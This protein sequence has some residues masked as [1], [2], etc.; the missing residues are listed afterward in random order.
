[1][2]LEQDKLLKIL[3]SEIEYIENVNSLPIGVNE[4]KEE[5]I[6]KVDAKLPENGE[7]FITAIEKLTSGAKSGLI[8]NRNPRFFGYVLAGTTPTA[9][10]ADWLTTIWNQN[11]QV[12]NSSPAAS[13]FEEIVASWLLELLSLPNDSSMGFVTGGQMA[14]FTAINI[15]RNTVLEKSGWDFDENGMQGAPFISIFCADKCHGT[16]L[17]AIRMNGF[18]VKNVVPISTDSE[19][20]MII[21]DLEDKL[22]NHEGPKIICSQAGNVNTGSFD[23]FEGISHLANKH[24][25]WHHIDG[26]FG[27][28][29]RVSSKFSKLT[30]GIEKADSWTVDAHKWLSVPFDSGMVITK[31]KDSLANL[32]KSRCA[33]S[34]IQNDS[35]R[36]GSQLVPENSRR[37]RGFV[38]YAT[39]RNFGR[40][41]INE[42]IEDNCNSAHQLAESL[43]SFIDTRIVNEIHLNQVLCRIEPKG[44]TELDEFHRKIAQRV[45]DE[46]ICWLGTSVWNEETVLRMSLT[47]IYTSSK[48]IRIA[49][50]SIRQAV[51]YVLENDDKWNAH[52]HC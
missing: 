2:I 34:G 5:L 31:H 24:N 19:G 21:S 18:G 11:A 9:M 46:G 43:E 37:A 14:N 45:Q 29:A 8:G 3:E 22:S 41:G 47:N 48:D 16:I 17:S 28:W 20:R 6:A 13:I 52:T 44:V 23:F 15:A 33:Y 25:A 27:L 26:A 35:K 10:A 38:L 49:V 39:I 42:I 50:N 4:S 30:K 51:D 32:K 1:M 12:F 7:D 36:D 40:K